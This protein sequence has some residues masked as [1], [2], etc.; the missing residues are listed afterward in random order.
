MKGDVEVKIWSFIIKFAI[1]HDCE[2]H[3][4]NVPTKNFM[5]L[6]S[7]EKKREHTLC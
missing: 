1:E 6:G 3:R 5:P 7:Q 4:L 2:L